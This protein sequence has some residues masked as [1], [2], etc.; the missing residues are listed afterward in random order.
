[1]FA[2]IRPSMGIVTIGTPGRILAQSVLHWHN[3]SIAQVLRWYSTV[4]AL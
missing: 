4:A 2:Q 1:M 3:T